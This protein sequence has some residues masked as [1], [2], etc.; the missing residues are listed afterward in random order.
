MRLLCACLEPPRNRAPLGLGDVRHVAGRHHL[1]DIGLLGDGGG[2]VAD[3]G[4]ALEDHPLGRRGDALLCPQGWQ[5][6][7]LQSPQ[8]R[9]S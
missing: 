2:A 5:V 1:G 3:L 6:L 7:P 9:Q 8:R 4:R